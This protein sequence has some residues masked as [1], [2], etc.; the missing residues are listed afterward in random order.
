MQHL[1]CHT[2]RLSPPLLIPQVLTF[3]FWPKLSD[4][5]AWERRLHLASSLCCCS[6]RLRQ[7]S[8]EDGGPVPLVR[9]GLVF[10]SVS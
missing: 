3:K 5:K 2:D 9:L 7:K 4:Q 8:E 10:A 1:C 6:G